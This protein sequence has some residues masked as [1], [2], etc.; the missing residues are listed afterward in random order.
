[1]KSMGMLNVEAFCLAMHLIAEKTRRGVDPPATL[2]PSMLPPSMRA[3]AP[4]A[5]MSMVGGVVVQDAELLKSPE[6]ATL[7]AEIDQ[8][9]RCAHVH[10]HAHAQHLPRLMCCFAAFTLPA[11]ILDELWIFFWADC[12]LMLAD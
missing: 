4:A 9:K 2:E 7:I 12:S 11:S 3:A 6:V 1:M 8:I 10:A 5:T